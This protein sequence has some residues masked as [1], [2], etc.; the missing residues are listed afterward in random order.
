MD[1]PIYDIQQTSVI[2]RHIRRLLQ[3]RNRSGYHGQRCAELMRYICKEA[4]IHLIDS[5]FLIFLL[6]SL[7]LCGLLTHNLFSYLQEHANV[8]ENSYEAD[9]IHATAECDEADFG[10]LAPYMKQD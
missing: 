1:I 3:L 6:L 7:E 10:R 8:I 9:G 2:I 4:H 5:L